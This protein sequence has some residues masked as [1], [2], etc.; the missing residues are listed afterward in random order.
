VLPDCPQRDE[1]LGRTGDL[2]A[3]AATVVTNF[4]SRSFR[5]SWLTDVRAE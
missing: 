4:E 2:T 3:F 1:R 5:D